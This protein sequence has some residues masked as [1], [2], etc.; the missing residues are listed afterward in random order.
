MPAPKGPGEVSVFNYVATTLLIF[1]VLS[2]VYSFISGRQVEKTEIP[3]SQLALD[4]KAGQVSEIVVE[5]ES[6]NMVYVSGE[7]KFTKKEVQT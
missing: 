3:L 1:L 5:G 6:L 4:I 2:G 7:K